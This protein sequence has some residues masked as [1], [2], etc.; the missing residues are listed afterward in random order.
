MIR[1]TYIQLFIHS[2]SASFHAL[3]TYWDRECNEPVQLA[4]Y[5]KTENSNPGS[6]RSAILQSCFLDFSA[7]GDLLGD[8]VKYTDY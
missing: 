2:C 3:G 8:F 5:W 4:G 6:M 1:N 7:D